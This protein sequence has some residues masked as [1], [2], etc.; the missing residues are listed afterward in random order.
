VFEWRALAVTIRMAF[1]ERGRPMTKG[2][3]REEKEQN[4][5]RNRRKKTERK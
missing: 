4:E 1:V 2:R 3:R 5:R